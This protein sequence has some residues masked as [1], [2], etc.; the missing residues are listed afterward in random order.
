MVDR[1]ER[2][3]HAAF[4]APLGALAAANP[5]IH[6]ALDR[7]PPLRPVEPAVLGGFVRERLVHLLRRRVVG[8]LEMEGAV[9]N[10]SAA[11]IRLNARDL[12]LELVK[13]L[14]PALGRAFEHRLDLRR[15][16]DNIGLHHLHQRSV[17]RGAEL[18]LRNGAEQRPA[19]ARVDH[20]MVDRQALGGC[21]LGERP[22]GPMV[23]A[24]GRTHAHLER[25]AGA[26]LDRSLRNRIAARAEPSLDVVG[27]APGLEHRLSRRGKDPRDAQ[28]G[29]LKLAA[30]IIDRVHRSCPR[31][32]EF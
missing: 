22:P 32:P 31:S 19:A 18:D 17:R 15:V 10:R 7:P 14:A 28:G 29:R 26:H 1:V 16:R 8:A 4:E 21:D 2:C 12:R 11:A 24:L 5:K 20:V 9:D 27:G 25:A 6:E 30:R 3:R 13:G 23:H